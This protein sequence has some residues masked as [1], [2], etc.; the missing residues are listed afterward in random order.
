[1]THPLP[2]A[3]P[4]GELRMIEV[5]VYYDGPRLFSCRNAAGTYFFGLFV[6]E[7]AAS[8]TFLFAPASPERWAS[9]RAGNLPL[10]AAFRQPED[11]GVFRQVLALD[12]DPSARVDWLP[13]EDVPE[14]WY[15][16]ESARLSIPTAI[17]TPENKEADR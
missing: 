17:R 5:Y 1:M 6:D 3:T 13:V 8:E 4:M 16:E 15:P 12:A 11:N 7:D 2:Q 10:A 9:V 14:D